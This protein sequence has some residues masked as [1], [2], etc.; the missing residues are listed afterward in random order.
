MDCYGILGIDENADAGTIKSAYRRLS[1][2][3]HPDKN[4]GNDSKFKDINEA[5]QTLSDPEKR[6]A[7]DFQRKNPFCG[8]GGGDMGNFLNSLFSGGG[9]P[10]PMFPFG[11]PGMPPGMMP[12]MPHVRIFHNGVPQNPMMRR[13]IPIVKSIEITLQ[14]AYMGVVLPL[15]IERWIG[16]NE[17]VLEKE[18]IYVTIPAGADDGEVIILKNRGNI[19][20]DTNRGDIKL[21]VKIKNTT[22]FKRKGMDLVYKKTLTLKEALIGFSFDLKFLHDKTYSINNSSGKII[23]PGYKKIIAGMGM[24]RGDIK[25]N[26]IIAFDVKFPN[27]L[28]PKQLT[29]LEKI[30]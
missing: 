30:L 1:L 16:A 12:G 4:S 29:D 8:G 15:E 27:S 13:P 23:T 7:Y 20:T 18:K 10:P 21:F 11:M 22:R 25:G 3:Y 5:Y 19:I 28:S 24:Q 6:Q 14:Q 2:K 26:L 9:G 17:K